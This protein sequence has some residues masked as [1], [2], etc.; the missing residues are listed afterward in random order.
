MVGDRLNTDILFGQHGGLATLLVL[1]GN[2]PCYADFTK[3]HLVFN[4]RHHSRGRDHR[5]K[6]FAYHSRFC[7][8]VC[9]RPQD[10]WVM[11]QRFERRLRVDV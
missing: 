9:R 5:P 10:T 6:S 7:N 11:E 1:T 8:R 2:S 4:A 3:T